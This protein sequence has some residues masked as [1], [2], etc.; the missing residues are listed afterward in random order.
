MSEISD[1]RNVQPQDELTE[2]QLAGVSGGDGN[3][4]VGIL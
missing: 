2:D 3:R 4:P 1:E